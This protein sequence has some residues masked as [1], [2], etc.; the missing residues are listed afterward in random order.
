MAADYVYR[1]ADDTVRIRIFRVMET[2]GW[3]FDIF[4]RS[5][6]VHASYAADAGASYFRS[7]RD[8]KAAAEDMY[9]RLISLQPKVRV[10]EGW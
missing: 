2:S 5:N 6:Q 8:A 7:R 4:H 3:N 1:N 10:T 9:G